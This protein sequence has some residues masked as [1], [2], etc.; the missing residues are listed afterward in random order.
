MASSSAECSWDKPPFNFIWRQELTMM[1]IV[2]FS[3]Q[4]HKSVA[5]W[6]HNFLQTLQ[7]PSAVQKWLSRDHCCHEG[8]N[9]VV[10]LWG[11]P[12]GKSWP[13]EPTSSFLSID[14]W[15]PK[16]PDPATEASWIEDSERGGLVMSE[17]IGQWSHWSVATSFVGLC[18]RCR[19]QCCCQDLFWD[20]ETKIET[21][22]FRSW[23]QDQDLWL[24]DLGTEFSTWRQRSGQN[25]K[26]YD[27]PTWGEFLSATLHNAL[28]QVPTA[29]ACCT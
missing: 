3:L 14:F 12:L 19:R 4:G 20:L 10:G 18:R 7:W 27:R 28:V 9:P 23:D 21:L 2:C 22:G 25:E 26:L 29:S 17:W 8:W 6:F 15:C 11:H 16:I 13:P 1:D 5:A 24:R